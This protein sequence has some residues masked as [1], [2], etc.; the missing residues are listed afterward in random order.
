MIFVERERERGQ[1]NYKLQYREEK[2]AM[3]LKIL[4]SNRNPKNFHF[5]NDEKIFY[6]S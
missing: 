3:K 2:K 6:S 4:T 5:Y 1:R